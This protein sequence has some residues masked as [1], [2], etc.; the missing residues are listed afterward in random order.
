M[1]YL[2]VS[3]SR[4]QSLRVE[5]TLHAR[6]QDHVLSPSGLSVFLYSYLKLL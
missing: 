6:V 5:I 1:R 3:M 4:D 2:L